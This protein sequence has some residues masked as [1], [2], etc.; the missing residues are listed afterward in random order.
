MRSG[1]GKTYISSGILLPSKV[2][3]LVIRRPPHF[4]FRPGDYVFVNIPAIAKYE[5]HPFTLSS[6]PEQE[7][8]MWLHIRGVG[9]W[10]NQL[11]GYFEKEQARLH[12][13][14]ILPAI[15]GPSQPKPKPLPRPL[16]T[17]R[18]LPPAESQTPQK[19][20][21]AKNLAQLAVRKTS[22]GSPL[23]KSPTILNT[24]N[25][26]GKKDNPFDFSSAVSKSS[27]ASSSTPQTQP[28]KFERQTSESN[29]AIRKIQAS[30]QRTFSRKVNSVQEG[31][32]N[33]GFLGDETNE[34]KMVPSI[35]RKKF[36]ADQKSVG[37]FVVKG[38]TPLEK[39]LSMPDI[40]NRLKKRERLVA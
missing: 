28:P 38:K 36:L 3:H 29:S 18:P 34:P 13:G 7:D 26:I 40:Q 4:Y 33:E 37:S 23:K 22:P 32:T 25:E 8:Y 14:E 15:V 2:T 16:P 6:A 12:S 20:F 35:A 9:E 39:S 24:E 31:Q 10:T 1:H 11:Y 27:D 17:T 5:W 19:D 30:L 21:L